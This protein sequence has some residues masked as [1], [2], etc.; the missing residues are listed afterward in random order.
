[1][2]FFQNSICWIRLNEKSIF[3]ETRINFTFPQS[4]EAGGFIWIGKT[5]GFG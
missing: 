3:W 4:R 1:M 5:K 2:L